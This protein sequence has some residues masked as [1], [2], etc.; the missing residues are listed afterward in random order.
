MLKLFLGF[1]GL[2]LIYFLFR[3]IFSRILP[4]APDEGGDIVDEIQCVT[5]GA[6]VPAQPHFTGGACEYCGKAKPE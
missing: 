4:G 2:L 3:A 5:C 6:Y 1:A